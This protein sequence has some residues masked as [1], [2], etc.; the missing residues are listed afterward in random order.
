MI[1]NFFQLQDVTTPPYLVHSPPLIPTQT[2]YSRAAKFGMDAQL[3]SNFGDIKAIF[4]FLL[5]SWD[6]NKK[7]I[8]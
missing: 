5:P 6:M 3:E 4:E 2:E 8:F 1:S 7:L